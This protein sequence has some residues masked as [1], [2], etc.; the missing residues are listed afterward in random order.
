[1]RR[2]YFVAAIMWIALVCGSLGSAKAAARARAATQQTAERGV[3]RVMHHAKGTF[4]VTITQ[5]GPED[6]AEGRRRGDASGRT[7]L[8]AI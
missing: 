8:T 6:K 1:M 4:E 2:Q 3:K 5:Q 7:N